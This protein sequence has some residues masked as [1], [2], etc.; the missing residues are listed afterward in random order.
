MVYSEVRRI[1][2]GNKPAANSDSALGPL[3]TH[4]PS[5]GQAAS[6]WPSDPQGSSV[7]YS[8]VKVVRPP[9]SAAPRS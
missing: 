2:Q 9:A 6:R 5:S 3:R 1:Q 8:Q 4:L 7:I